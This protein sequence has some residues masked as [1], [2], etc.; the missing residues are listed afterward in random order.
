MHFEHLS[1]SISVESEY[2]STFP[3]TPGA[4]SSFLHRLFDHGCELIDRRMTVALR[5]NPIENL[6][7][8]TARRVL[9]RVVNKF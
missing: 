2:A 6:D 9:H 8:H 3:V 1:L 7:A 4:P 5:L